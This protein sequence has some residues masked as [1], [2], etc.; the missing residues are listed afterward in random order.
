MVDGAD[1]ARQPQPFRRVHGNG[2]IEDHHERNDAG[3]D[4][5]LLQPQPWLGDAG[6]RIELAAAQRGRHADLAHPRCAILREV[7]FARGLVD[8]G[9][10]GFQPVRLANVV[11]QAD[12]DGLAA[13]GRR[14]AADTDQQV[15]AGI[16]R[17]VGAGDH[18][19]ARAVR[20]HVVM[21]AGVAR[22]ERSGDLPD[23]IGLA[24]ERLA[25]EDEHPLGAQPLGRL[26]DSLGGRAAEHHAVHSREDDLAC[27][28]GIVTPLE[29]GSR[30]RLCLALP[31]PRTRPRRSPDQARRAA[32]WPIPG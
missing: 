8:H 9:T 15:A 3:M 18:G 28:H 27:A 13:V 17:L 30:R 31:P 24:V 21:H 29:R 16:A 5:G 25:G 14:P 1:A 12:G 19:V 10:E 22:S 26:G 7:P 2:G 23:R 11:F 6:T 32:P 20:R 4:I